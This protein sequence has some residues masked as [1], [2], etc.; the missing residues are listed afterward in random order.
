[1]ANIILV[2]H[3][4]PTAP[5]N[6]VSCALH[7]SLLPSQLSITAFLRIAAHSANGILLNGPQGTILVKRHFCGS[8]SPFHCIPYHSVI[9]AVLRLSSVHHCRAIF[10]DIWHFVRRPSTRPLL[11]SAHHLCAGHLLAIRL[12]PP[13]SASES[14]QTSID[15]CRLNDNSFLI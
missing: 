6:V 1:M 12:N 4:H 8:N 5:Y 3:F 11:P 9:A 14:P 7:L 2:D 13:S 10:S 15:H